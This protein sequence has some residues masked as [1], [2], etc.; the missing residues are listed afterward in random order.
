VKKLCLQALAILMTS[1]QL[2]CFSASTIQ[3]ELLFTAVLIDRK[4]ALEIILDYQMDF[5]PLWACCAPPRMAKGIMHAMNE[6]MCS[7]ASYIVL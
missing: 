5:I 1:R 7:Q 6:E 4:D 2:P 3:P